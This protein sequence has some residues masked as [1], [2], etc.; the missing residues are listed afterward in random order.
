MQ[1]GA[2]HRAAAVT[3]T[4]P[5]CGIREVSLTRHTPR[6]DLRPRT[7]QL[8]STDEVKPEG[9][10]GVRRQMQ[11]ESRTLHDSAPRSVARG[12]FTRRILSSALADRHISEQHKI[13]GRVTGTI[14]L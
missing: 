14:A 7:W 13:D 2:C 10:K 8:S 4:H 9:Y 5:I 6:N 1:Q 11:S 12:R 3:W